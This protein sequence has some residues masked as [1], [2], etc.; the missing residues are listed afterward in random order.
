MFLSIVSSQLFVLSTDWILNL[1]MYSFLVSHGDLVY[2]W[3]NHGF[4]IG[5]RFN[6][7]S[8]VSSHCFVLSTDWILC[9]LT[10]NSGMTHGDQVGAH[11]LYPSA[12]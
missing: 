10:Y 2:N 12:R 7:F 5:V 6:F 8:T 4:L 9:L 1:L 3:I 11:Q